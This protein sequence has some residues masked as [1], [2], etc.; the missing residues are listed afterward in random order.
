MLPARGVDVAPRQRGDARK[1]LDEVERGTFRRQHQRRGSANLGGDGAWLT[2][3]TVAIL[4]RD[5]N[6]GIEL[7]EH[8]RRDVEPGEHTGRLDDDHA[9]CRARP[10]GLSPRS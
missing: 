1:A 10:S 5:V 4:E 8:F 3:I 6:G 7:A 2:P 9:P